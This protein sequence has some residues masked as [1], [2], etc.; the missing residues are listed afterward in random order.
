MAADG[1][2]RAWILW[3]GRPWERHGTMPGKE[4]RYWHA[5]SAHETLAE[6]EA[7]MMRSVERDT[8]SQRNGDVEHVR[9]SPTMTRRERHHVAIELLTAERGWEFWYQYQCWPVGV[10]PNSY[11]HKEERVIEDA[12]ERVEIDYKTGDAVRTRELVVATSREPRPACWLCRLRDRIR[13][14]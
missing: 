10:T 13:S 8:A 14:A 2:P 5:V 1:A 4:W 11:Q 6:A 12:T 9:V 3:Y 7:E